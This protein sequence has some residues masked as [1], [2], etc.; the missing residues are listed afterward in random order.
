[1]PDYGK[2]PETMK[3]LLLILADTVPEDI[4]LK[5]LQKT[6]SEHMTEKTEESGG[7]LG[8]ACNLFILKQ[9]LKHQKLEKVLDDMETM[10]RGYALLTPSK[11]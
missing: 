2:T 3:E 9:C 7:R 10:G 4:L 11:S 6:L 8:V 5:E 1:M